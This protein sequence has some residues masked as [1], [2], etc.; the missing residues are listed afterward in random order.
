M[1][2]KKAEE[3]IA[4]LRKQSKNIAD[5]SLLKVFL[6]I[7]YAFPSLTIDYLTQQTMAQIQ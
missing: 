1:A 3:R 5:D 4:A 6:R 7:I 2:Q